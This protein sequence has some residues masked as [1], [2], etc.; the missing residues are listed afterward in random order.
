MLSI[1]FSF[2]IAI[3][4]ISKVTNAFKTCQDSDDC[5]S[6]ECCI[7]WG[8]FRNVPNSCRKL[9]EEGETCIDPEN[10]FQFR[11]GSYFYKCP[12]KTNLKCV[13]GQTIHFPRLG[14]VA[15]GNKCVSEESENDA[16]ESSKK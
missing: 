13:D 2:A 9:L 14:P 6:D 8:I 16:D 3:C 10:R 15:Y 5:E 1:I 4:S 12:C 7:K 11:D